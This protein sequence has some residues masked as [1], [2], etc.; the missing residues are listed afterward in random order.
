MVSHK[1]LSFSEKKSVSRLFGILPYIVLGNTA[2]LSC[3]FSH[4]YLPGMLEWVFLAFL[5][6]CNPCDMAF[7]AGVE[8]KWTDCRFQFCQILQNCGN[9]LVL[10]FYVRFLKQ[11]WLNLKNSVF[12]QGMGLSCRTWQHTGMPH[13]TR[14]ILLMLHYVFACSFMYFL[15]VQLLIWII[16]FIYRLN[17]WMSITVDV[18]KLLVHYSR[19]WATLKL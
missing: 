19:R 10:L 7:P 18:E 3:T 11:K 8:R 4:K 5:H 14:V 16:F 6:S 13:P 2:L 15:G 1:V 9:F 17:V 12:W